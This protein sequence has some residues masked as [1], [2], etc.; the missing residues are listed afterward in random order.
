MSHFF[1]DRP[2]FAW[3]IA[4]LMMLGGALVIPTSPVS[5]YPDIAPPEISITAMFPGA[6]AQTVENS[7]TQ[8]IE[9]QMKGLDNFNYMYS[10]SDS[11]GR[12]NIV[13]AFNQEADP[14]IAH[15]QV[16]NKLSLATPMLPEEVQR[17]GI[18]VNKSSSSFFLVAAF[19]SEDGS[20]VEQDL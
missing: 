6:S 20:M 16:Q 10:T 1:I 8:I 15:V 5:Q 14:D 19:V 18:T 4:I 17:N 3:V 9:Q 2:I 11:A 12:A 13:I 7:V